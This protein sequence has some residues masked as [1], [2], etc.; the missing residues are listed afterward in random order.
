VNR[1]RELNQQLT[2]SGSKSSRRVR[3][4]KNAVEERTARIQA[5]RHELR[6]VRQGVSHGGDATEAPADAGISAEFHLAR[7]E[8][9]HE[10]EIL[11]SARKRL[12]NKS[13][14]Q[15]KLIE[16]LETELEAKQAEPADTK[17]S[18]E[19]LALL[20]QSLQ[21]VEHSGHGYPQLRKR[22]KFVPL[23]G[24]GGKEFMLAK[25][26]TII[27]RSRRA[28]IRISDTAISRQHACLTEGDDGFVIE[29][30]ASKNGL[31]VNDQHTRHAL[32]RNGDI[33]SLGSRYKFRFVEEV[34]VAGEA[35]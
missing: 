18:A 3:K 19:R 15:R 12:E 27:G 16:Q 4:L 23:N 5:L 11:K 9:E 10:I 6:A 20:T 34:T 30:V 13:K 31:L 24:Y 1:L 2:D 33:V 32:L 28:D 17:T 25:Q 7:S 29:D 8:L 14:A 22:H 26:R 21:R 35:S